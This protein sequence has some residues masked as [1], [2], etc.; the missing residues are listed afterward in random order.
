[1]NGF[2]WKK[3]NIKNSKTLN[4]FIQHSHINYLS[5][6][7]KTFGFGDHTKPI[8]YTLEIRNNPKKKNNIMLNNR[9]EFL[10]GFKDIL[11][12]VMTLK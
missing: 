9:K 10:I 7:K 5:S 8:H 4:R 12:L 6:C 11:I 2:T 3:F 1:M